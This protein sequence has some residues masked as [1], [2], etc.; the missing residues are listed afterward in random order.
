MSLPTFDPS[1]RGFTDNPYPTYAA[2]RRDAP[3][4]LM[5]SGILALAR[6]ADVTAML[7]DPRFGFDVARPTAAPSLEPV[8]QMLDRWILFRDPP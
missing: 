2:L 5:P 3:L 1:D 6:H 7:K 4:S 8:A